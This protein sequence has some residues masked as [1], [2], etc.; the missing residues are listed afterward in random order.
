MAG[1]KGVYEAARRSANQEFEQKTAANSYG[2]FVAQQRG[3][4]QL[5]DM[6]RSWG[7]QY[8]K[9][10]AKWGARG[11]TGGGVN[12]GFYKRAMQDF[13][14]DYGRARNR[15]QEG[16]DHT[17]HGFDMKQTQYQNDHQ[18]ALADIQMREQTDIA[19]LAQAIQAVR[20]GIS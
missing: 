18:A 20:Q 1:D 13:V 5:G 19:L 14:G 12:S 4:R 6:E 15:A 8:P 10:G 3:N 11:H 17:L 9:F 2:R 7:R 16:L